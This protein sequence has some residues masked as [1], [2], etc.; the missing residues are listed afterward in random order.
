MV[1]LGFFVGF[2]L[3]RPKAAAVWRSL[4]KKKRKKKKAK[5][6]KKVEER[7]AADFFK[8]E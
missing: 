8:T 2:F 5:K 6:P 1:G 7:F 3:C 4:K